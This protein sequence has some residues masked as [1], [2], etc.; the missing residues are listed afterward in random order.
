MTPQQDKLYQFMLERVGDRVQ[1]SIGEMA[2]HLGVKGRA[3]VHRLLQ[4]LLA[5]RRVE[6]LPQ[7]ERCWRAIPIN[8]LEPYSGDQ[9]IAEL[10]RRCGHRLDR[11]LNL[12][13]RHIEHMAA[14]IGKQDAEYCF[15]S[16]GE[17]MPGIQA[18]AR[19]VKK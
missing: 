10:E 11:A 6:K 17:D 16:L 2:D 19:S 3:G 4:Q 1:P 9:L 12:A 18:A 15:E 8:P 14:W 7:A 5:I 13:I